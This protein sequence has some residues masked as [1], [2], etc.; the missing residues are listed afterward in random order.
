M[1]KQKRSFEERLPLILAF[2]LPILI[3]IGIFAG[4]EI[5][6]FGENC[7]LRTDL[8]HQYVAFFENYAERLRAGGSLTYAFDIGLG[9]NYLALMAYYLSGPLHIFAFLIPNQ[10]IIEFITYLIVLKIGLCG[11]SMAWY[12]AK[13]YDTR[14]FGIAF[15]G[16]CYA[17]S[18]Y[19]AAYSWNIM[20]LDVLW[21]APIVIYGLEM[22]VEK[23]RP[24][25]YVFSLGLAILCNYYISI[26]LCL[27]LVLYFICRII[28][29]PKLRFRQF[30]LK[31]FLF[32]FY[33]VLAGALAAVLVVPAAYALMGT[34]SANTTFPKTVSNYFSIL[35]MLSR[36][37]V[38]VDVETG[39]D[40]W[41]NLYCGVAV[42]LFVPLYYMNRDVDYKEKIVNT[43][44]LAFLLLSFNTNVLNYIW[45]GFHYPNSLPCRQS[46]L[47][48]FL[49]LKMMFDGIRSLPK[50]TKAKFL[51][52][53]CGSVFLILIMEV[54]VDPEE[55]QYY[56]CYAS[57][58][59]IALYALF[60]YLHKTR[61]I[62]AITAICL[63]LCTL[64]V[65]MGLNTA[66]TSVSYVNRT[67]FMQ[68]N[69]SY[70]ELIEL[71]K[72]D[73]GD[74]GF[75]RIERYNLRTKNDGPYF[76][77]DSASIFSSTTNANISQFYKKMGMEG[78]TNAYA[79]TGATP[80]AASM[81][82]VKYII[83]DTTLSSNPLFTYV[84]SAQ[85]EKGT[86]SALYRY[87]Y[88]LPFGYLLPDDTD[89][90][91]AYAGGTPV[92][93]QNSF[94]N[95][96]TGVGNLLD[97]VSSSTNGA[98]MTANV[99]EEGYHYVYVTGSV[100]KVSA[101][102]NG[103]DSKTWDNLGRGYFIRM[104]YLHP[105]DEIKVS[106]SDSS[107]KTITASCYRFDHDGFIRAYEILAAHPFNVESFVNSRAKTEISGSVTADS[108]SLLTFSIPVEKGWKVTVD[109]AETETVALGDALL[110]VHVG[111][112][113]HHVVLRYEA[114]GHQLGIFV[115][116]AA[117]L[118]VLFLLVA[119]FILRTA[120][121]NWKAKKEQQ[122]ELEAGSSAKDRIAMLHQFDLE[123]RM[124]DE[125]TNDP[126][127]VP[128]EALNDPRDDEKESP[129]LPE[130]AVEEPYPPVIAAKDSTDPGQEE[131]TNKL[132]FEPISKGKE[133]SLDAA[134]PEREDQD[135]LLNRL[136]FFDE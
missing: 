57:I 117:L 75:F 36:H 82:D 127:P 104:G 30:L 98:T 71:A 4:K 19:L 101:T 68:Y 111:P 125:K 6:P 85:N 123:E 52:T 64:I 121:Q 25:L 103:A 12:L 128:D 17:L 40:H 32:G 99:S 29:V 11:L 92:K 8:Y 65:E 26:M 15:C 113:T 90:L 53:L 3:M 43:V 13:R 58:A 81:L 109:G 130:K 73:N 20:W 38:V 132:Q 88:T 114:E 79:F 49:V 91:W 45:H 78:N 84:G 94:I 105:G 96:S 33:S 7:F 106:A 51:G 34:A 61:H 1:K 76:G 21:L 14:H 16:I 77:Y 100:T 110:S 107:A 87:E 129:I 119:D 83:S 80:L 116:L 48:N 66:V 67:T 47:Y 42:F 2:I 18:G 126:L 120:K 72:S 102:V 39:L 54:L 69:H 59:F 55:V 62:S 86:V 112:G 133:E 10:Y 44:L 24:F 27:F 89:V 74:K 63:A 134:K 31:L 122:E 136:R 23:N 41:P 60:C 5:W 9:S 95:V 131:E 135:R 93:V 97:Q 56:A 115:S 37:L 118:L 50:I 22:L 46:Y 124:D 70:D 108:A 28:C 35:E